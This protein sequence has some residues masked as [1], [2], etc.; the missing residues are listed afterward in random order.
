MSFTEYPNI[1][2][3]DEPPPGL[4]VR[5]SPRPQNRSVLEGCVVGSFELRGQ[6]PFE[7][8]ISSTDKKNQYLQENLEFVMVRLEELVTEVVSWADNIR[9]KY[10]FS[11][12]PYDKE[13][14]LEISLPEEQL[15]SNAEWSIWLHDGLSGWL[16]DLQGEKPIGGQGVF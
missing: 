9:Q 4:I 6:G 1:Y 2:E 12:E 10:D 11:S 14:R 7:I 15:D 5:L 13:S 3:P 16:V 8:E